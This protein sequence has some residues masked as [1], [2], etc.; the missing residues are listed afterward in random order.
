MKEVQA[1]RRPTNP[2]TL[3]TRMRRSIL[4]PSPPQADG[5]RDLSRHFGTN[6]YTLI[7]EIAATPTKQTVGTRANRYNLPIRPG[8]RVC[9]C[10]PCVPRCQS[11]SRLS[12]AKPRGASN[13]S[14]GIPRPRPW[15]RRSAS[16][17]GGFAAF[18][19]LIRNSNNESAIRNR[20]K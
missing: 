5:P 20:R 18:S 8:L 1:S 17:E 19:P 6:R 10:K 15:A 4:V 11:A 9:T 12:R 3:Q 2:Y 7:I 16:R 14:R 13:A